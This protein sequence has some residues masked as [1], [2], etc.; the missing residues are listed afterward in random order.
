MLTYITPMAALVFSGKLEP[1]LA[2]G[3]GITL[4][5]TAAIGTVVALRRSFVGTIVLP[6]PSAMT[7]LGAIAA[8]I[9]AKIP[10]KGRIA[11]N[12]CGY[13]LLKKRLI[14]YWHNRLRKTKEKP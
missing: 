3:I 5:S 12:C 9:A 8:A 11:V 7:I 1:F 2:T 6:V 14:I 10:T 4:F 13:H